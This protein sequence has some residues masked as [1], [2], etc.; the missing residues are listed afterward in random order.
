M[1]IGKQL[2]SESLQLLSYSHMTL[3]CHHTDDTIA[4]LVSYGHQQL[5]VCLRLLRL[6]VV[7]RQAGGRGGGGGC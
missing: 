2:E 1:I 6:G 7:R 5:V 4:H 3:C